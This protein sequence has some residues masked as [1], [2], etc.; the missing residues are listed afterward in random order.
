MSSGFRCEED[1]A[2]VT[3]RCPANNPESVTR[4]MALPTLLLTRPEASAE[5]FAK[6]LDPDALKS[7][8]LLISPLMRIVSTGALPNLENAAGVI[9]TS[10]NGVSHAP[11]GEGRPAFCVGAQTTKRAI[12]RGWDAHMCG[13]CAQELIA[14]LRKA[15]PVGPLVHLGG[16]QTIG[17]I[18]ETLTIDGIKTSH[19]ALY[20]QQLLPL[21][22]QA[23]KA[24]QGPTILP[25]F[26]PRTAK[27]LI[28][29][30]TG[31]LE[32]AHV[33]ALSDSV[34]APLA[35]EKLSQCLILPSPQT[36]FMRKAVENLCLNLSPH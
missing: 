30:A 34:A 9:F 32:F 22:A 6:T 16:E 35:G 33:I 25:L 13:S 36:L 23:K 8:R 7:V 29:E 31:N 1:H 2:Q 14:T 11:D 26:S 28:A 3:L 20:R 27:Q 5:A 24:I 17:D 15:Q 19:I 10:A 12:D 18:A 21:M 4:Y